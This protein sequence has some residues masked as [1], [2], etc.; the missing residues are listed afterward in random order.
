MFAYSFRLMDLG[1]GMYLAWG[2]SMRSKKEAFEEAMRML[3]EVDVG[4]EKLIT[5][6]D[7][8]YAP[9]P[10]VYERALGR[11]R[12]LQREL[13]R[14]QHDSRRWLKTKRRL[15]RAHERVANTRRDLYLKLGKIL[16][17][18]YDLVV[19]EDIDV[20][21]LVGKSYRPQRRRLHDVSFY[22]LKTVIEYQMRKY[23]KDFAAVD[24]KDTS[25]TC[26]RCGYVREDLKLGDRVYVC[27]A[28]GWAADRD[29]NAALNILARTGRGPPAVPVE[30]RTLPLPTEWQ[31]G[32][33]SR[34]APRI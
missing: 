10:R 7:G 22:E 25:R 23:G 29:Y 1:T 5:T 14:K 34:E 21:G 30:L 9:N 11:L 17:E 26:A 33:M 19:V 20:K 13:S 4:M 15:A 24:P 28:C 31:G 2:S 32:A 3:G 18:L 16:A 27:P 12:R 8:R 6:S